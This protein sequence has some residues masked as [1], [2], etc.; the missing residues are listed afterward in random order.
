MSIVNSVGVDKS[1]P[2]L[3]LHMYGCVYR[4]CIHHPAGSSHVNSRAMLCVLCTIIIIHHTSLTPNYS[5]ANA[6]LLGKYIRLQYDPILCCP[7]LQRLYPIITK[8]KPG[9]VQTG[10]GVTLS[11]EQMGGRGRVRDAGGRTRV[12]THYYWPP[13][14]RPKIRPT[15]HS[16]GS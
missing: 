16:S 8:G 1:L 3:P 13:A 12:Q 10:A 2:S 5:T 9:L 7:H 11:V 15:L 6:L 4:R 14:R